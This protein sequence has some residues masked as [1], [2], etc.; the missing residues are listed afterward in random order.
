MRTLLAFIRAYPRRSTLML[1]A[2]L[3][4]GLAEGVS[5]TTMLPV[6]AA[7]TGG[8]SKSGIGL[9]IVNHIRAIGLEPSIGGLLCL[10]VA[11]MILKSLLLLIANRQV[12]YTVAHVATSL[13]RDLIEALLASRWEYYL[14]Q[15]AGSLA[16]SVATEA[17]R[18]STGFEY[19][20]NVLV[21][22]I[23]VVVYTFVAL[24]I[25]WQATLVSML[26]ALLLMAALHRLIRTARRAGT[27]QT[28][29]LRTLLAYLTD[30]LG[31]VKPLKAMAR[32]KVADAILHEQTG[33]LERALRREV[34]SRETMRALHEPLLAAFAAI[35]VYLALVKWGLSLP[36]VMMLV[37][38]LARDLSILTKMQRTYQQLTTQESAYWALRSAAEDARRE[39]EVMTGTRVPIFERS[40]EIRDL[41]F[42]YGPVQL[43]NGL[44]LEFPSGSFTVLTGPS[45]AGKSTLLDLIC[46]LVRAE[47]G[48]VL[49]DGVPLDDLDI[50]RWRRLIGYV[51]QETVLLHDTIMNN[52]LVGEPGLTPDD[53]AHALHQAGAWEFVQD[54]PQGADTIVG[55]RGG[56]L[57]GGQRQRIAIAR[58]LA[59]RPRLLILDEPT[60]ALDPTSERTICETLRRLTGEL[61]IIAASHQPALVEAADR[62]FDV[63]KGEARQ[64]DPFRPVK[65]PAGG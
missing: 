5:L 15:P 39:Q 40:V 19:G 24:V 49:V 64:R 59:H 58:A 7:A 26:V 52:I 25:S 65:A 14:R 17:Y 34:M 28:R 18:A 4:A 33:Q 9:A 6:L 45:G 30:V 1:T 50:R 13:R 22:A 48:A 56:L 61:T 54:L 12:G 21:L 29:L 57:S 37:F 31:S 53:A 47:R 11:G 55:E 60:S 27:K 32:D 3:V 44:D 42:S 16:N 41:H 38:L 62:I 36:S 51:P 43:F 63:A 2:L 35:G 23:Q 46:G 20:A 10:I 8:A